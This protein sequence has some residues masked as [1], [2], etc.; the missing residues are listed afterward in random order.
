MIRPGNDESVG[1]WQHPP[2]SGH[3][4]WWGVMQLHQGII[5]KMDFLDAASRSLCRCPQLGNICIFMYK[6]VPN[7]NHAAPTS[8]RRFDRR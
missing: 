8:R 3:G 7:P 4:S 1:G 6:S 5:K 2:L